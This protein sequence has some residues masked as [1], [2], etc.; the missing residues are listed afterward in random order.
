MDI[1]RGSKRHA[2]V[3]RMRSI[4]LLSDCTTSEIRRIRS[5]CTPVDICEG[6]TLVRQGAPSSQFI[7]NARG[8]AV[9]SVDQRPV[10][11][12][13]AGSFFGEMALSGVGVHRATVISATHMELLVFSQQE[14]AALSLATVPSVQEKIDVVLAERRQALAELALHPDES[15]GLDQLRELPAL[16]RAGF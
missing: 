3:D 4:W 9:V 5:L 13:E 8:T 15:S 1:G 14:S 16:Q 7:I 10:A 11:L 12:I 6:R 2:W